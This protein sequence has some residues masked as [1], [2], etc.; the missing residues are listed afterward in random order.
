MNDLK[1]FVSTGDCPNCGAYQNGW[2]AAVS[3]ASNNE[4][5]DILCLHCMQSLLPKRPISKE[6][7]EEKREELK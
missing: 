4:V 7:I 2:H 1:F 6:F 3:Q 5:V